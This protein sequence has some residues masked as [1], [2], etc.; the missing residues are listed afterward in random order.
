[1][2]KDFTTTVGGEGGGPERLVLKRSELTILRKMANKYPITPGERE[3]VV[4]VVMDMVRT[5]KS[6]RTRIAAARTI[7]AFD[8]INHD[9]IKTYLDAT[10]TRGDDLQPAVTVN[11]QVNVMTAQQVLDVYIGVLTEDDS[12]TGDPEPSG[13]GQQIHPPE[14]NGKAS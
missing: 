13:N 8:K 4:E 7:A 3:E 10:K 14:T 2:A 9:E 11:N 5:S 1:M 6:R 12:E